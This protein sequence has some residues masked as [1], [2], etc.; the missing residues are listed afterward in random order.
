MKTLATLIGLM[1]LGSAS[2][3]SAQT[4]L[5][6]DS[7]TSPSAASSPSQRDATSSHTAEAPTT[8]GTSPA[9]ASSPHQQQVTGAER[10]GGS[11]PAEKKKM[12]KDC[13]AAE[14]AKNT[15]ASNSE[16]KRTCMSQAKGTSGK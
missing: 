8:G 9:S 11:T 14:K 6:P 2:F 5:P 15:G 7:A 10:S 12:M 4:A 13:V 16:M 3:V 1:A